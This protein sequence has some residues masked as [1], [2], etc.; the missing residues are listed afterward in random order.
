MNK[1]F[2]ISTE[3]VFTQNFLSLFKYFRDIYFSV[4]SFNIVN[5]LILF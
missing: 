5:E 4:S 3:L 1:G 2:T